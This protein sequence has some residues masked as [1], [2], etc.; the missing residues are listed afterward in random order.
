[1]AGFYSATQQHD[2]AA[3]LAYF[4]TGAYIR[5]YARVVMFFQDM[6]RV[7]ATYRKADSLVSNAAAQVFLAVNDEATAEKV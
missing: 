5:A 1:M 2:A 4:R 7:R 6:R 3:P